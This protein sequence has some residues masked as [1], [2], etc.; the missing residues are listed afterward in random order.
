MYINFYSTR[1]KIVLYWERVSVEQCT[2]IIKINNKEYGKTEKTHYTINDL[3]S[4]T[5]YNISVEI[6]DTV[7]SINKCIF[8]CV[9]KTKCEKHIIDITKEPYY[10]RGDGKFLNTQII[11]KAID[12]CSINDCIY[13]PK[14]VFLSGALKLHSDVEIYLEKGAVLQGTDDPW[15]YLP[16]IESRFEGIERKCYSSLINIGD[17][18]H[19]SEI[20]C[21]NILIHGKGSILGGGASLAKKIIQIEKSKPEIILAQNKNENYENGNTVA[22]RARPRLINMSNCKNIIITGLTVG[23]G[24][25]WNL[26]MIYS[27]NIITYNC[28]FISKNVWNGDGWDPDSSKNCTI[29]DCVFDT[30]DDAIAIKSGKNPEGNIINR[31]CENIRIFDCKSNGGHGITI[32][33]EISGGINDVKIWDCDMRKSIYGVEIK[34]TRKRGGYVKNVKVTN[35]A[36]SRLLIHTVDYNDDGDAATTPPKFE[37]CLFENISITGETILSD[38][39]TKKAT[40]IEIKGFDSKEH[41]TSDIV[42][43]NIMI[44]ST[45][46]DPQFIEI[47]HCDRITLENVVCEQAW[48]FIDVDDTFL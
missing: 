9:V 8:S 42:L 41:Y 33:S 40:C 10:A 13:I 19:N 31:P 37:N 4:D 22:G 38:G 30:G 20:N 45:K 16:I 11:Q 5:E 48:D 43:R 24:P 7:K 15:D 2:N 21:E 23:N 3:F 14:G 39:S 34:A 27:E 17:M 29:F 44:S 6:V 1:N 25:C 46:G 12:Q 36:I 47:Q 35:C 28:T 18:N 26:H 32:G